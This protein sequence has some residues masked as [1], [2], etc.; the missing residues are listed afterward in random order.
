MLTAFVVR[1]LLIDGDD[2]R[3]IAARLS[4]LEHLAAGVQILPR[5][6]LEPQLSLSAFR[7][8]LDR[9]ARV[10]AET[11]RRVRRQ[12]RRAVHAGLALG[13]QR[14]LCGGRRNDDRVLQLEIEQLRREIDR[15]R[16]DGASRHEIDPVERLAVAPQV[17]LSAVAVS[18]VVVDRLRHVGE[19]HRLE[20]ERRQHLVEARRATVLVEGSRIELRVKK[21]RACDEPCEPCERPTARERVC[22]WRSMFP[23]EDAPGIGVSCSSRLSSESGRAPSRPCDRALSDSAC[24]TCP[25]SGRARSAPSR[26]TPARRLHRTR[27]GPT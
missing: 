21:R 8:L 22:H 17:P 2:D 15:R 18:G 19:H 13:M 10:V 27:Q 4:T 9:L 11:H 24:R 3:R 26:S 12:R 14:S 23:T 16:I 1:R 25:C 5:I 20:V 6:E 7:H